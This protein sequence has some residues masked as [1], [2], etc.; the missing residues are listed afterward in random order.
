M[1]R[2]PLDET[3]RQHLLALIRAN[4]AGR[5]D[6]YAAAGAF[7]NGTMSM[8]CRRLADDLANNAIELQQMALAAGIDDV[9]INEFGVQLQA[10]LMKMIQQ[11]EGDA[12]VLEEAEECEEILKREYDEVI[13]EEADVPA[14]AN[15]LR[16]Q[17][18]KVEFGEN[19]VHG[20]R[21]QK[22]GEPS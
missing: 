1:Q 17:R 7:D 3:T 19:V 20:L 5:D 12:A 6:L 10:D 14:I 22:P 11:D 9:D 18:E 16:E 2:E 21:S 8:I 4:F 15:V 13:K